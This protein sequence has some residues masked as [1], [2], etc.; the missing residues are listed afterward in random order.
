MFY[1]HRPDEV[2]VPLIRQIIVLYGGASL[3]I[4]LPQV[5]THVIA[6]NDAISQAE[7]QDYQNENCYVHVLRHYW[8]W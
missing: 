1:F 6:I 2:I 4:Y 7:I 3:N 8:V 5:V